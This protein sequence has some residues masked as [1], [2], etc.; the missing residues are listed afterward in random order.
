MERGFGAIFWNTKVVFDVG[1]NVIG[2]EVLRG[3]V[4]C[5]ELW[6]FVKI[7]KDWIISNYCS[8]RERLKFELCVKFKCHMK[9]NL[10]FLLGTF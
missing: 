4:F 8:K 7:E 3:I 10:E 9:E 6:I 5:K 2:I 1:L